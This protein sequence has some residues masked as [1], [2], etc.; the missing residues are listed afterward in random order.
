MIHSEER[1]AVGEIHFEAAS[2]TCGVLVEHQGSIARG[3]TR[4]GV[5]VAT[6]ERFTFDKIA[7][8]KFLGALLHIV[9]DL[10]ST[11]VVVKARC[12]VLPLGSESHERSG[13]E[14]YKE[15]ETGRPARLS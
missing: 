11:D 7:W 12:D 2:Q 1:D 13:L 8:G 6:F 3:C 15:A 4:G 9:S 10:I 5:V 14:L